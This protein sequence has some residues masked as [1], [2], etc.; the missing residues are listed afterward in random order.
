[1]HQSITPMVVTG[2]A[3]HGKDQFCTFLHK[4]SKGT[5]RFKDI[6][7]LLC[8]QIIY[9]LWGHAHYANEID[10]Y[11]DRSANRAVWYTL[12]EQYSKNDKASI[13]RQ[14]FLHSDI[15]CGLRS[16]EQ[17]EAARRE[18]I[19]ALT[20]WIDATAR[21]ATTESLE[22]CTITAQDADVIITNNGTLEQLESKA[23]AFLARYYNTP[24][25]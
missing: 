16:K 14:I 21:T 23:V 17:L 19:V 2:F 3:G 6:S 24:K 4:A 25:E 5:I 18:N 7:Q 11:H 20:V 22:S 12:L 9:P 1:M 15:Y 8:Q 10:C 13:I